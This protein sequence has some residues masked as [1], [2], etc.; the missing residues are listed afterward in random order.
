[1]E[2]LD[3]EKSFNYKLNPK[4]LLLKSLFLPAPQNGWTA[5]EWALRAVKYL[6]T[7][8]TKSESSRTQLQDRI[9]VA[10]TREGP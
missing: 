4:I 5:L 2:I 3:P 7:L 10:F 6:L 8:G 9:L 1:M